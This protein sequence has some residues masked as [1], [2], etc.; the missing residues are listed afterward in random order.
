V[1]LRPDG[2]RYGALPEARFD[3]GELG[4]A[5]IAVQEN[6]LMLKASTRVLLARLNKEAMQ[7]TAAVTIVVIFAVQ[8]FGSPLS[9]AEVV[10]L[11][12]SMS[13]AGLV[14]QKDWTI[15]E[16][17]VF[18]AVIAFPLH[19]LLSSVLGLAMGS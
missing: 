18:P 1:L 16:Q 14:V 5:W 19:L 8:L 2:T 10:S 11:I 7:I 15:V 13:A 17:L 3:S 12:L 6:G 9:G 4:V